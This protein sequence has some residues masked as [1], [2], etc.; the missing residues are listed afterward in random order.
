MINVNETVIKIV[1][2]VLNEKNVHSNFESYFS[3]LLIYN[4]LRFNL[5]R[6]G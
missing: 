3:Y 1:L 2:V 5:G 4:D 6:P